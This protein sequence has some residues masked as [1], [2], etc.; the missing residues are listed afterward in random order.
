M[1]DDYLWDRSGPP[2]P[3][4]ERLERLLRPLAQGR[5]LAQAEGTAVS[6]LPRQRSR[7]LAGLAVAAA[8]VFAAIASL[9]WSVRPSPDEAAWTVD[10][11]AGSPIVG[12]QPIAARAVL[13]VGGVVETDATSRARIQ[14]G[15]IGL[16]D[17]DPDTRLEL[18]SSGESQHRLRLLRG[19]LHA[20]IVAPPGYRFAE[21]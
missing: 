21:L 1:N 15:G 14:V 4:V 3:E 2:D 12:E 18:R 19:T 9:V 20:T 10:R 17:V 6:R 5:A 16:V 11:L 13:R 8:L 7:R